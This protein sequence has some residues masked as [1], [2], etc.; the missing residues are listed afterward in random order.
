MNQWAIICYH[1]LWHDGLHFL[2][3]FLL[4]VGNLLLFSKDSEVVF[5]EESLGVWVWDMANQRPATVHCQWRFGIHPSCR[6]F[7]N[8]KTLK[9]WTQWAFFAEQ[10][11]I[12]PRL[13]RDGLILDWFW[14][15]WRPF[16]D[17][18]KGNRCTML[19]HFPGPSF[20][21]NPMPGMRWSC[22]GPASHRVLFCGDN[23][24]NMWWS[25]VNPQNLIQKGS[26]EP[27]FPVFTA[28]V[29]KDIPFPPSSPTLDAMVAVLQA[30]LVTPWRTFEFFQC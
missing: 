28:T 14:A 20:A 7:S 17:V 10:Q 18:R 21:G 26:V 16:L 12:K 8:L 25:K 30:R 27:S 4:F 19:D 13:F 9:V 11:Q 15:V 5:G 29:V 1:G 22:L 23:S 2:I 3:L 6:S 24:K